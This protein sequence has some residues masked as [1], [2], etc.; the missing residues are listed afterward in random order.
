[1]LRTERCCDKA[2][3]R[4]VGEREIYGDT[5]DSTVRE[6]RSK[7]VT[8]LSSAQD[9]YFNLCKSELTFLLH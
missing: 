8:F 7:I 3:L 6:G 4:V 5:L 2:H 1:M 9:L